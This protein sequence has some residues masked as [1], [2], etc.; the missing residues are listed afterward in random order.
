MYT[1]TGEWKAGDKAYIIEE[2]GSINKCDILNVT[3][4]SYLM[5][6]NTDFVLTV[7]YK[8]ER[9]SIYVNN[10]KIVGEEEVAKRVFKTRDEAEETV[11]VKRKKK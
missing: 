2:D 11:L 3:Y 10:Y 8:F 6:N 9:D 4:A 1:I 5:Y 7:T